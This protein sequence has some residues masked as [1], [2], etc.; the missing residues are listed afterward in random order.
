MV[1]LCK[2]SIQLFVRLVK[3]NEMREN[4]LDRIVGAFLVRERQSEILYMHRRQENEKSIRWFRTCG[5]DHRDRN[6][7]G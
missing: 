5:N 4:L 7:Y 6:R 1:V 3:G 2:R